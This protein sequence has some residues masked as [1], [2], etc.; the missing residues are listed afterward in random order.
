MQLARVGI[1]AN[2]S[3]FNGVAGGQLEKTPFVFRRDGHRHTLLGFGNPDLPL[4][5]T[6]IFEGY[7]FQLDLAAIGIKRRFTDRTGQATAAIIGDK[8]NQSLVARFKK[9]IM[10]FLLRVGVA[11]LHVS[12]GRVFG[13]GLRGGGYAVNA[14]FADAPSAHD[15]Q[16]AGQNRF[17]FGGLAEDCGRHDPQGGYE[18][19]A[20]TH[21]ALVE[22][23]LAE[24]CGDTAFVAAVAHPFDDA[25]QEPSR[26]Q[27]RFQI[28]GII[29]RSHAK[30]VAAH[31]QARAQS[32]AHW[33][34]INTHNAGNCA[35]V[36]L[37]V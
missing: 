27:M 14:V 28:T 33:I 26:V 10:H 12:G 8:T 22:K 17:L 23:H 13:K 31:D 1:A 6:G 36:S 32:S 7:L 9:K 20:F 35:A 3:A 37:H 15:H 2:D 29:A 21:V 18:D 24:R 5:Q 34:A 4:I 30:T 11:N 19:Q 16:I 25:I